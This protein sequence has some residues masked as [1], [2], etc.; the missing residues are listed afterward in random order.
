[1]GLFCGGLLPSIYEKHEIWYVGKSTYEFKKIYKFNFAEVRI[2]L[3]KISIF[4]Q[5]IF[6]LKGT[7]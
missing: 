2:F 1:M 4:A 7:V 6:L 3:Q 5:N